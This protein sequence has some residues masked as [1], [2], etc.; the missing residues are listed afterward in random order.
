MLGDLAKPN[1][2]RIAAKQEL[3]HIARNEDKVLLRR[4]RH[5][6]TVE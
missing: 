3:V 1:P 2:N 5:P 6:T 4:Y